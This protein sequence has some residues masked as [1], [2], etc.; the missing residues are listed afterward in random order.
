[1]AET[2]NVVYHGARSPPEGAADTHERSYLFSLAR[3]RPGRCIAFTC[4]P[5]RRLKLDGVSLCSVFVPVVIYKRAGYT[6]TLS[7]L[8]P[9][10]RRGAPD[11]PTTSPSVPYQIPTQYQAH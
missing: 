7:L 3:A 11:L 1:M 8:A 2:A 9:R 4:F 10:P 6:H 5:P